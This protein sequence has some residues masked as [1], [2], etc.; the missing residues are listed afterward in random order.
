MSPRLELVIGPMRFMRRAIV[1]WSVGLGAIIAATLAFWPA[2]RGSSGISQA[3][4]QLP[5]GVVT[6]LGLQSFGTPAGYLR[7]NLY[8]LFLPLLLAAAAIALVNGQTAGEEAS[9]RLELYLAQP[10]DRRAL[11]LGR[12][13]AGFLATAV[14][15]TV[16][17]IAQLAVDAAV[18]LQIES[19]YLLSTIVLCALLAE[20]YAGLAVALA[21]VRARPSMVLGIGMG[22]TIVGY[23]VA[24]LFPLSDLLAPW[25]HLSPWDW[26]LGGNPLE[27]PSEGWRYVALAISAIVLV[28]IGIVAFRRRDIAAG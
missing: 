14:L 1:W 4:D 7:G 21:G 2:F 10:V 17:A 8:E 15:A 28:G 23:L 12:A 25:R 6:A 19:S 24:A 22:V 16:V 9:G 18:D 5:P 13:I 11:F 3:L 27:G 20:V 26:A